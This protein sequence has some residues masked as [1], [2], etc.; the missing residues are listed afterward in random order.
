M[1]NGIHSCISIMNELFLKTASN[2]GSNDDIPG[3]AIMSILNFTDMELLKSL[4]GKDILDW[5]K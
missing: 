1:D 3:K 4:I 2:R 5:A